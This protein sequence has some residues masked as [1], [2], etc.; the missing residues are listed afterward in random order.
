MFV[1]GHHVY[2]KIWSPVVGES[3]SCERE[4]GNRYNNYAVAVKRHTTIIGHLPRKI[5]KVSSLFLRKGGET[6]CVVSGRCR[7]CCD[8]KQA[9][10]EVPCTIIFSGQKTLIEKVKKLILTNVNKFGNDI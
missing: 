8:L 1:H 6:E 2:K 5:S 7:H 10:L 3:L 4:P 9:G